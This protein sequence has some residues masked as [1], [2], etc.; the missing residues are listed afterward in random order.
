MLPKP[1]RMLTIQVHL[2]TSSGKGS[3]KTFDTSDDWLAMRNPSTPAYTS[4]VLD[5]SNLTAMKKCVIYTFILCIWRNN[6][7]YL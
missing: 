7:S 4:Q 5:E 1:Q 6:Q 3:L 2:Q